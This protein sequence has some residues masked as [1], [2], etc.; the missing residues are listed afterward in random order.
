MLGLQSIVGRDVDPRDVA[1]ISEGSVRAGAAHVESNPG[2]GWCE[3]FA[4]ILG[5]LPG[6][7]AFIGD[8]IGSRGGGMAHIGV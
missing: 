7:Y 4:Y 6:Y 5:Q 3:D 8:G 1:V 2:L